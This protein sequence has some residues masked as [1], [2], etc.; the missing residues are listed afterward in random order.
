MRHDLY[1]I[2]ARKP[3]G[4]LDLSGLQPETV[5]GMAAIH[6]ISEDAMADAIFRK[7]PEACLRGDSISSW[8]SMVDPRFRARRKTW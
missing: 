1:V 5:F 2:E 4:V 8:P 3:D 7:C 6:G